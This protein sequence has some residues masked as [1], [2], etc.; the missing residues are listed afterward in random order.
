[1][2]KYRIVLGK[3]TSGNVFMPYGLE[4][5]KEGY[6]WDSWVNTGLCSDDPDILK[7]CVQ[8]SGNKLVEY[9]E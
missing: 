8:R 2:S 9:N 1:M 3:F 4:R 7:D 5:L 6:F